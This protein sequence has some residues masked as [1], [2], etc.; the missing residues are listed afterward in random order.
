MRPS[1]RTRVQMIY[2]G[3]LVLAILALPAGMVQAQGHRGRYGR[4]GHGG[5]GMP[6][7]GGAM[8][9]GGSAMQ[10]GGG[11]GVM[12]YGGGMQ[13]GG[14]GMQF[15]GG[16]MQFGAVGVMNYGGGMYRGGDSYDEQTID[17]ASTVQQSGMATQSATAFSGEG[18]NFGTDQGARTDQI[19]VGARI[20]H[21]GVNESG[22]NFNI[23]QLPTGSNT[24]NSQ[25]GAS[26]ARNGL[27]G[28]NSAANGNLGSPGY[29]FWGS[30][31]LGTGNGIHGVSYS[32]FG[33]YRSHGNRGHGGTCVIVYIP[34]AGWVPVPQ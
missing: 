6:F 21:N 16:Y 3:A 28:L 34:G 31:F 15:A 18:R 24:R 27:I 13:F 2:N 32:G 25:M 1:G 19:G 5:V 14:V 8:P 29:S 22:Q 4:G 33:E 26:N 7:G 20:A 12:T 17:H 10:F 11:V 30:N 9:F 23:R